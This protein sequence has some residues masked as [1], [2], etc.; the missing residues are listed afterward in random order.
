MTGKR[1]AFHYFLAALTGFLASLFTLRMGEEFAVLKRPLLF[2]PVWMIP[3]GW[4]L[5]LL[6]AV[7]AARRID[8]KSGDGRKVMTSFYVSLVL[9][10]A[11]PAIFFRLDA[12]AAGLVVL[13]LLTGVWLHAMKLIRPVSR[14]ARKMLIACCIWSGYLSY[15]N[16]G[17]CVLN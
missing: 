15:I 7:S 17:I 4:A 14:R 10:L 8:C 11:W 2:P 6:L 5:T 12:K 13:L 9:T 16:L 1:A 3:V